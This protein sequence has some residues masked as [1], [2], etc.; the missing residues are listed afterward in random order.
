MPVSFNEYMNTGNFNNST[1][2]SQAKEI[3]QQIFNTNAKLDDV[4][5]KQ[6]AEEKVKKGQLDKGDYETYFSK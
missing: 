1:I 6:L 5:L 4:L 2:S 3:A